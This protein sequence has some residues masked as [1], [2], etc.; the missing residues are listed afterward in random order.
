MDTMAHGLI[1]MLLKTP[2]MPRW[3]LFAALGFGVM[4]DLLSFGIYFVQRFVTGNHHFDRN[5]IPE[6]VYINYNLTHSLII[7]AIFGI[8]I[9]YF[10]RPGFIPYLAWPIHILCDVPTH[11]IDFFATP[12][13]Y[14][15]WDWKFDGWSFGRNYWIIISYYLAIIIIYMLKKVNFQKLKFSYAK[16]SLDGYDQN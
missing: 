3:T 12:I 15:L 13:F 6:Y 5:A 4:P 16:E 7:A 1:G 8:L 2:K 14:P 9:Y 10:W 11:S